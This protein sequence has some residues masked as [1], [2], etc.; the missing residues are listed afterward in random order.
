[1]PGDR[2]EPLR[3]DHPDAGAADAFLRSLPVLL[4]EL[5]GNSHVPGGGGLRRAAVFVFV[6][7]PDSVSAGKRAGAGEGVVMFPGVDGFHWTAGHLIFLGVFF[8]VV[9]VIAGTVLTAS[10]R[11]GR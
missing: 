1:M 7:L 8:S 11:A 5:A 6:P 3:F 9:I 10:I 2:I 4:A